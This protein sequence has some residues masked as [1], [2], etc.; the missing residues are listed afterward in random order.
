MFVPFLR[1]FILL[2]ELTA[3]IPSSPV[4]PIFHIDTLKLSSLTC[5]SVVMCDLIP[6]VQTLFGNV[7]T[8]DRN[9]CPSVCVVVDVGKIGKCFY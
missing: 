8:H 2:H 6:H 9:V 1:A 4:D 7:A 3:V 5:V